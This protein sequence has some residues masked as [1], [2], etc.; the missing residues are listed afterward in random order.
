MRW[1]RPGKRDIRIKRRFLWWP[2]EINGQM[3]WLERASFSQEYYGPLCWFDKDWADAML[4]ARKGGGDA[5]A[6]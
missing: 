4:E 1:K 6:D 3:R 2:K 5:K